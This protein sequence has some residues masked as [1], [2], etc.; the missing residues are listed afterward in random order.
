MKMQLDIMAPLPD[1]LEYF[2]NLFGPQEVRAENL[3]KERA[4]ESVLLE[5][6]H[7]QRHAVA[8]ISGLPENS[9]GGRQRTAGIPPGPTERGLG[10]DREV[11]SDLICRHADRAIIRPRERGKA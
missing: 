5:D 4:A 6:I 9:P 10:I 7:N 2:G 11:D 3:D 1:A 8:A